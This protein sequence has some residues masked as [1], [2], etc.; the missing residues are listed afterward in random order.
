[1]SKGKSKKAVDKMPIFDEEKQSV[2]S[3]S[4]PIPQSKKPKGK[5]KVSGKTIAEEKPKKIQKKNSSEKSAE[6]SASKKKPESTEISE[7][8]DLPNLDSKRV[9]IY[10]RSVVVPAGEEIENDVYDIPVDP[11]GLNLTVA[12]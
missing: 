10:R 4:S 6:S 7:S 5:K 8:E 1:L 12:A 2:K 9:P 11:V 3:Q